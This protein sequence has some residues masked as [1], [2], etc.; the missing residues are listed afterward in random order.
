M[1]IW[2]GWHPCSPC[3]GRKMNATRTCSAF[4]A[5]FPVIDILILQRAQEGNVTSLFFLLHAELPLVNIF[6]FIFRQ[7][8]RRDMH[9]SLLYENI[10]KLK[11]FF[12]P[13]CRKDICWHTVFIGRMSTCTFFL[14]L[15]GDV[16]SVSHF[17]APP[18]ISCCTCTI[19]G[20]KEMISCIP[21]WKVLYNLLYHI[22]LYYVYIQPV[23]LWNK[24]QIVRR[25]NIYLRAMS[26]WIMY[27]HSWYY[28]SV[29]S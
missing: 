13:G 10:L 28:S 9:F 7:K 6:I 3:N 21:L 17:F 11:S 26:H 27:W 25:H 15:A 22:W 16:I 8:N 19:F 1:H 20:S 18:C 24:K 5:H 29:T 12:C 2:P 14:L 23:P 4:Y